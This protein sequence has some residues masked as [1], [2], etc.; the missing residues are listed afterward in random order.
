MARPPR[1]T[2]K[3]SHDRKVRS[4]AKKTLGST[5]VGKAMRLSAR[6]GKF[7]MENVIVRP[8]I[9]GCWLSWG[10]WSRLKIEKH[11]YL[12]QSGGAVDWTFS[13][14][15]ALFNG[16]NKILSNKNIYC[17]FSATL[18]LRKPKSAAQ[19]RVGS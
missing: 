12:E 3:F 13:T 11:T 15:G 19:I 9:I 1:I 18:Q 2:V 7:V 8:I 4:L 5:R 14:P 16:V 17:K 10:S 6:V